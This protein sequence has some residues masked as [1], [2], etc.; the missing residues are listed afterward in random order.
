MPKIIIGIDPDL[1]KSGVALYRS[2]KSLE[3]ECLNFPNVLKLFDKH[4]A[5][6]QKVV[7]EAG[8]LIPKSNWHGAK[9]IRIGERKAKN[10]GE[11][12]AVGKLLEC[13]ARAYGLE[14][15][16]LTPQGK[17]NAEE[18]KRITGYQGSTNQ[19]KRD[20]GLLVYGMPF[21]G[22]KTGTGEGR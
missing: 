18:F 9:N 13:C 5:D 6:I 21:K 7:I 11:N 12:H 20:A 10:V 14:V 15:Q 17:K 3:L 19:E 4:K 16:L 22:I 2:D 1:D 8:W